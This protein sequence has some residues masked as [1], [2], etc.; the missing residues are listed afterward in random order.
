MATFILPTAA[1]SLKL[2]VTKCGKGL[3]VECLYVEPYKELVRANLAVP[4]RK[5]P[6]CFKLKL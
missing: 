1:N 5:E 4:M 6:L 3:F 2:L